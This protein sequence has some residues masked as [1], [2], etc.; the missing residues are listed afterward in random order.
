[1]GGLEYGGEQ[2]HGQ[3]RKDE[4]YTEIILSLYKIVRE[5]SH[6]YLQ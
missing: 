5:I 2:S 1:M 4:G 6:I 3:I